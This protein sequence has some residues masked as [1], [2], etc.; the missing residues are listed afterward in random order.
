MMA[1]SNEIK[2]K[3]SP[4]LWFFVIFP[5]KYNF[6]LKIENFEIPRFSAFNDFWRFLTI[7]VEN[8]Q[9]LIGW[10]RWNTGILPGFHLLV[11]PQKFIFMIKNE[12]FEISR[13]SAY[14]LT[15]LKIVIDPILTP[16]D[17]EFVGR[18]SENTLVYCKKD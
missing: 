4:W 7:F 10:I 6:G 15:P 3:N 16:F 8:F 11:F 5:E 18:N 9:N 12:N 17:P 14:Q 13:N 1:V 2:S